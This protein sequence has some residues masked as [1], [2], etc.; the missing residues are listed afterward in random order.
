MEK[1]GEYDGEGTGY[2][3]NNQ[4]DWHGMLMSNS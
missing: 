1:G 3:S 4:F 2:K